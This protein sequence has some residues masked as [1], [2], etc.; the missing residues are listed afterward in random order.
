MGGPPPNGPGP[1]GEIQ[2]L[3]AEIEGISKAIADIEQNAPP[4]DPGAQAVSLHVVSLFENYIYT[5][6]H[7]Y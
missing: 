2:A 5:F 3:Q 7:L 4:D 6:I 1:E